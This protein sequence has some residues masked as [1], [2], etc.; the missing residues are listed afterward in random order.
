VMFGEADGVIAQVVGEADLFRQFAQHALVEVAVHAGHAG[1]DL[2]TAGDGGKVEEGRFHGGA[3][4]GWGAGSIEGEVGVVC[5][6]VVAASISRCTR[7]HLSIS[8]IPSARWV[9]EKAR[10]LPLEFRSEEGEYSATFQ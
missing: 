10:V 1:L 8:C 2:R 9:P 6:G 4:G 3:P 5:D 7:I